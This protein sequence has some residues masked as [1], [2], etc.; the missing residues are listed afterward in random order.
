M[1]TVERHGDGWKVFCRP[2]GDEKAMLDALTCDKLIFATGVTSNP[3]LPAYDMSRFEGTCYH[4]IELGRRHPELLSD[5]VQHVTVIGG[6]KS[7]L[8][9]VGNRTISSSPLSSSLDRK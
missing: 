6:H 5:K 4:S 1:T 8:E 9:V 2:V 3:G 7:A